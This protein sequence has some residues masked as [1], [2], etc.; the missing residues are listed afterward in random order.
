MA[1]SSLPALHFEVVLSSLDFYSFASCSCVSLMHLRFE[2]VEAPLHFEVVRVTDH[3]GTL[4][5]QNLL[6]LFPALELTLKPE[7]ILV[8]HNL[9]LFCFLFFKLRNI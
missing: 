9:Q 3:T 1:V 5:N 4:S 6:L 7:V 2:A 8:T